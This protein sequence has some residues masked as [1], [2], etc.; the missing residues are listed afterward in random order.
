MVKSWGSPTICLHI[1]LIALVI[2]ELTP[3]VHDL[4]S[5]SLFRIL[6][7]GSAD[8][9]AGDGDSAPLPDHDPAEMPDEA[10][11]SSCTPL[12]I[13]RRQLGVQLR[14]R[15]VLMCL[16]EQSTGSTTRRFLACRTRYLVSRATISLLC[17]RTC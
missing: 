7:T 17:R 4:S 8:S 5:S 2:P 1:L 13:R 15:P 9:Q 10:I 11:I 16:G 6:L 12:A 3:D 14:R